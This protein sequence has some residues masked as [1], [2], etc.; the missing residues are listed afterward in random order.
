M[1]QRALRHLRVRG[2]TLSVLITGDAEMRTLNLRWRNLDRTTDVLSF[3]GD[4]EVLGDVV[5]SLEQAVRQSERFDVPLP[6]EIARLLVHGILHLLG[7]E[8]G[9]PAQRRAMGALTEEIL[10]RIL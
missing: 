6:E 9:T 4:G 3:E 10:E 7:H 1:A 8:H 2:R 5:I